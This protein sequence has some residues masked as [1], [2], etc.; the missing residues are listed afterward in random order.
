LRKSC[1]RA[2][3]KKWQGLRVVHSKNFSRATFF[4]FLA[5]SD[6]R[7][8]YLSYLPVKQI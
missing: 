8:I 1:L 5:H 6:G 7:Y 2:F 3:R 4:Y